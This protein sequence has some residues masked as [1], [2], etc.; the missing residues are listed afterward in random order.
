MLVQ[1]EVVE[2]CP[3]EHSRQKSEENEETL[4]PVLEG[5][6]DLLNIRTRI[7]AVEKVMKE[8]IERHVKEKSLTA[9]SDIEVT[10]KSNSEAAP[11]PENDIGEVEVKDETTGDL[12]SQKPKYENVSL[13][14]DIPL[15]QVSDCS[16]AARNCK[17]E[18]VRR[19]HGTDDQML[20]LWET[21][22]QDCC[23]NSMVSDSK[24]HEPQ[25][26]APMDDVITNCQSK[27][28]GKF[29]NSSSEF[30]VEK[31]LGVD[32]LE[33]SRT[34]KER[35][36]GGKRRRILERLSSDA[37]KLSILKMT[38]QDLK[39]KM[40]KTNKKSRKGSSIESETVERQ[41]EE[42]DEAV[43][44]LLDLNDQLTKEME[45]SSSSLD[46]ETS[47]ESENGAHIHRKRVT[48]QARRGSE[49]IGRLQFEVQNIQYVLLKLDDEVK[50]KRKN[51]FSGGV[52]LRD[53]IRSDKKIGKRRSKVC[54]C[55]CSRPSTKED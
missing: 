9:M 43:A 7:R 51:K 49:Q 21:A 41:I 28:S 15:D 32:K 39:K 23:N 1:T 8:E 10:E 33:L 27:N 34:I 17:R 42:V 37:Q 47:M 12:K 52:L 54:F 25:N 46:R 13:M 20:E 31:E 48:E 44:Q 30:E 45:E 50:N 24:R 3:K 53:F 14:K 29:Q 11:H 19:S 2:A 40:E 4:I 35:T 18:K 36:Q 38:V 5:V 16:P 55:G 26:A 22:E 6:S